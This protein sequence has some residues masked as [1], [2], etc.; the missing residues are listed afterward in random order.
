MIG[1]AIAVGVF[2]VA[3][4]A[5]GQASGE[6]LYLLG[7]VA[8]LCAATTYLSRQ[9][10]SFL[11]IFVAIFSIETIIFG[12][13]VLGG[14]LRLWPDTYIDY[15][16]P[17]SLALTVAIF[18]ILVYSVSHIAVI[19][20]ITN[21]ADRYFNTSDRTQ[22]RIWPLPAYQTAERR[23]AVAMVVFLVLVNQA[24]VGITVRLSFFNRDWF[25]AIQEKNAH[26]FWEL[27]FFVFT[28]WAFIYVASTVVEYVVQSTL[29]I[30]WRRWLTDHYVSRW[31]DGNTH[32]RMSLLG[33]D[34]D[35]PDQR[36]SE[37]ISRF[38]DAPT[39]GQ[40]GLYGYSIQ[41]ISTLSSLV[42]FAI[43]L[44]GL[45]AN[46]TLPGTDIRVPGFLFWVALIYAALG[47]F[48][49]HLIGRPLVKILFH[50][51]RVEADFRFSLAR[52]REYG[53]QVALLKG[54]PAEKISLGRRFAAIV[55]NY[56][57]LINTRKK[58]IAFTQLYGQISPII[59]FIF[60][61]P[62]YFA[63][64]IPLGIMTQTASAF[65]RV[66]SALTFF[67]TYYTSLAGFKSVLD[68]LTLFE[69]AI[70]RAQVLGHQPPRIEIEPSAKPDVTLDH[71]TLGLPDGRRIVEDA[72]LAFKAGEPT[73][74]A[75]PSGSGKSTMFRGISGIWPFGDGQIELPE[76]ANIM[77]LPQKP[78][79]PI[80]TLRNAVTYP[81]EPRTYSDEAI[82]EALHAADLPLLAHQLD[83]EDIWVQRLSGGEQQRLAIARALLAKPDWL[84]LDEA[85]AAI[86]EKMEAALYKEMARR[87]PQTTIVSIGHRSTLGHFHDRRIEMQPA[88]D[89]TFQPRD[90]PAKA[91][92]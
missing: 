92:E 11:K 50:K 9:I 48:V 36:I 54:E 64:R 6:G 61:A 17:Q 41:L 12:L 5:T 91:A 37:D 1:L 20:N 66:E 81:A 39:E 16:P 55:V 62:F 25:N 42:S 21:I 38:I 82:V 43:V 45:S 72:N 15:L 10:S 71:V 56:F 74:V 70:A 85:T 23:L 87:L 67:I 77:L 78:Y 26:A 57:D 32:Y 79:I 68:R 4:F 49:T 58:L 35:N 27:L 47:T 59:P 86:D 51:Q 75:G 69:K 14:V 34:A 3:A 88:H 29:V 84:F 22:A 80:G 63:G 83:H 52:L 24:Q 28:P 31:L 53:E 13:M 65:G 19:R 90:L 73:L 7:G 8:T 89:G 30:R 60:A 76:G 33:S 2:A 18:S 46:F 40:S 44:W